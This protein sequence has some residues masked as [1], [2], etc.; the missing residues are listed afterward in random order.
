MESILNEYRSALKAALD[1]CD[2]GAAIIKQTEE[3]ARAAIAAG[4]RLRAHLARIHSIANHRSDTP[5][6]VALRAISELS[7]GFDSA[8]VAALPTPDDLACARRF[9][10]IESFLCVEPGEILPRKDTRN[11][12]LAIKSN[13]KMELPATE[14]PL[15]VRAL[16]DKVLAQEALAEQL[17]DPGLEVDEGP[18]G[19][20]A[21]EP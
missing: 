18:L 14:P 20:E 8:P 15:T 7:E 17:L 4:D 3:V 12:W 13:L 21:Q 19:E 1:N 11:H 10:C 9:R 2:K 6:G 5:D 16:I